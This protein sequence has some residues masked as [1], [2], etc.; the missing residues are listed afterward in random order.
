[1][2]HFQKRIALVPYFDTYNLNAFNKYPTKYPT[3]TI[4][5]E[6]LSIPLFSET[7]DGIPSYINPG[8]S[9]YVVTLVPK[10]RYNRD[11]FH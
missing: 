4:K 1:M 2:V 10:Q 6:D 5:G 9:E 7:V 11:F 3:K 8:W